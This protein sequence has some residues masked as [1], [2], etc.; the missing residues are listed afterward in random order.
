MIQFADE[1]WTARNMF[2]DTFRNFES[3]EDRIQDN[4]LLR[5]PEEARCGR[6]AQPTTVCGL[7]TSLEAKCSV[8]LK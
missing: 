8:A 6:Q 4:R 3:E 7:H 2:K 1:A 5:S